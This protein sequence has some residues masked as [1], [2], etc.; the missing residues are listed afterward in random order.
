M[1]LKQK[2]GPVTLET[3]VWLLI[4]VIALV[5]GYYA[6][7]LLGWSAVPGPWG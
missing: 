3:W 2:V 6:F 1:D 5:A 7:Y 4:G